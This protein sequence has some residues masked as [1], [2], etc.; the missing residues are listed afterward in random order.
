MLMSRCEGAD[1]EVPREVA[2]GVD[3]DS[4]VASKKPVDME[5]FSMKLM[6]SKD[7]TGVLWT[8]VTAVK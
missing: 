2:V 8:V 1:V 6:V 5:M 3:G 7:K 4:I